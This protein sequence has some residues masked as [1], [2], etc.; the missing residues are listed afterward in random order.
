MKPLGILNSLAFFGVPALA[1]AIGYYWV[2]PR[3]IRAGWLPY[4]AYAAAL[5]VP[6]AA[7][8]VASLVVYAA[9]GNPLSWTGLM[10]RFRYA[11]LTGRD[12]VVVAGVFVAEIAIYAACSAFTSW[13][14]RHGAIP[15]PSGL[16]A[17][18][19]PRTIW[20]QQTIDAATG[21]LR[22][23]WGLLA[24]SVALLIINVV[25]EEFWW[26]GVVLPRQELAF[27]AWTLVAHAIMWT[28]FHAFKYWDLINLLPLSFGLTFATIYL[29]NSGAGLIMHFLSNGV[30]LVPIFLGV[31]GAGR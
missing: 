10:S 20:T 21:G 24:F 29:R 28:L 5:G 18:V 14:I 9:E 17:F 30:G 25:G 12:L 27:G 31:I 3:L 15:I 6:L 22:G 23:N 16:P 7:L 4:Y 8:L 11:P 13:L 26:R 2:M 19:D 1:L